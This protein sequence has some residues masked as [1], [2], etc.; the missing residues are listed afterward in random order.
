MSLL[1]SMQTEV[2]PMSMEEKL[3]MIADNTG[4]LRSGTVQR[5][6]NTM[7]QATAGKNATITS[8]ASLSTDAG[9]DSGHD[10]L[11]NFDT[12][13]AAAVPYNPLIPSIGSALHATGD[14]HRCGFF[15]KGR[16]VNG[17]NC[18]FCHFGHMRQQRKQKTA[19]AK[20]PAVTP[21]ENAKPAAGKMQ[22]PPGVFHH[23]AGAAQPQAAP[24]PQAPPGYFGRPPPGLEDVSRHTTPSMS[25]HASKIASLPLP[26]GSWDVSKPKREPVTL[27]LDAGLPEEDALEPP[28]QNTALEPKV[29]EYPSCESAH[30]VRGLD[31]NLPAKKLVTAFLLSY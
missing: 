23:T 3:M 21:E 10:D 4:S 27:S 13:D 15:P 9:S 26:P 14:C 16:C 25:P 18:Q 28:R 19:K 30:R 31:P 29:R 17:Y 8:D 12:S 7:F 5:Q 1:E 20:K 6:Q 2:M 22:P 11:S 24:Q